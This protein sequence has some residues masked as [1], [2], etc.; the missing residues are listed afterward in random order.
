MPISSKSQTLANSLF[1]AGFHVV[2]LPSP[3]HPSFIVTASSTGVPGYLENDA[4]DLYR[5]MGMIADDLK[6]EIGITDYYVGGYSLGG[7]H[8]AYVSYIDAQ[9]KRFNFKKAVVINPA[10]NL[11][12]S[13]K[14]LDSMVDKHLR[15]DPDAVDRFLD[16]IFDQ[17][18]ALYSVKDNIDF[19][20][21]A[22]LYR[23]YTVLEPPEQ[24]L[25][26]LIGVTFRLTSNDMAFTSDV[27]TNAAY[28]VPKNARLTATTSLTDVMIQGMRLNFVDYIDAIYIPY[29]QSRYP[30]STRDQL[31]AEASLQPIER[32]LRTDPRVVLVGTADDIILS[33]A[34]VA[35]LEDVFGD[36][37]R[38]F[39]TGGHCGS[40]DQREFVRTILELIV[41]PEARS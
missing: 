17:V 37:A 28:V 9:E 38:I 25:E 19:T 26:L 11:F 36:R 8:T 15:K 35:W 24:E 23:A 4:R 5:V 2:T 21:N 6:D 31:I 22:F 7:T 3:T 39:P 20:D 18:I 41:T 13:V 29:M 34:E 32:Y 40:M 33:R 10:V 16:H 30:G 1:Q 27:M 14:I 12:N